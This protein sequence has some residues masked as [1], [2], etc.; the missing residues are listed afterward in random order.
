M[1][2][3]MAISCRRIVRGSQARAGGAS[4]MASSWEKASRSQ[5]RATIRH[6]TRLAAN[7]CK[8]KRLS[9]VSL[10]QRIRSPGS[11]PAAGGA[12]RDRRAD[13]PSCWWRRRSVGS[14]PRPR[15]AAGRPDGAALGA[16][17]TRIPLGQAV[18]SSRSVISA[19]SAPCLGSPSVL[20]AGVQTVS[21]M[22]P[23]DLRRVL[24]KREPHAVGHPPTGQ[25][26]RSS[27][28]CLRPRRCAPAPF[29]RV[30]GRARPGPGLG[31]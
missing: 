29:Y 10:A 24:G 15:S 22:V 3:G 28:S 5:A 4:A 8:G 7:P 31:G 11:G 21:G 20:Y 18:R 13:P 16:R 6:Q 12:P 9:P 30:W 23:V 25:E 2:A 26:L 14:R 17:L 27:P 19:T 1:T